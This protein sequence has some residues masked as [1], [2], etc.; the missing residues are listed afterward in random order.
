MAASSPGVAG[1]AMPDGFRY[2]PDLVSRDEEAALVAEIERLPFREIVFRGAV[3]RRRTVHFGWLYD[4][5]THELAP[6][7]PLP[8]WLDDVRARAAAL[9]DRDAARLEEALIT[10]YRPGATIGWHRDAPAFG[11]SVVGLSLAAP[12]RM[13][14]RRK[15]GGGWDTREATLEPRSAYLLSGAA[16]AS[17]QHSIPPTKALRYSITF[18]TLRRRANP[19]EP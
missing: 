7:P 12:C 17:W 14:F 6:G 1:P 16:R 2:E 19:H 10:E 18:R 8:A 3:A 5:E 9:M 4:L 11:S 13:R 15:R